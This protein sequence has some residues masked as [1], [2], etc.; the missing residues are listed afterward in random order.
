MYLYGD[1]DDV[2]PD[3]ISLNLLPQTEMGTET[4]A[5]AFVPDESICTVGDV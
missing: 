2:D 1:E 4:F 5:I 3:V